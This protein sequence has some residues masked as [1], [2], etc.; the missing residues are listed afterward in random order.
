MAPLLRLVTAHVDHWLP[1]CRGALFGAAPFCCRLV[2]ATTTT[3]AQVA[4]AKGVLG[5][6]PR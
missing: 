3:V 5:A 4:K 6:L 2:A 1:C